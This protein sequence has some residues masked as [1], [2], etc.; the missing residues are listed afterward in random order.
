MPS[1]NQQIRELSFHNELL[2]NYFR[3]T[4]IPQLFIDGSLRL[5]KFSPPA[6][7]QFSLADSDIG[8][9]VEEIKDNF[10][11]PSIIDNIQKVIDTG[12]V[13]EKEIQT[14]DRRWYQ[15]NI[16]PYIR[17]QD[18]KTDGVIITFVEITA[19]IKDLKEQEKLVADYQILLDTISHD[20]KNPLTNLVLAV[21]LFKKATP[22][23]TKQY[24]ALLETVDTAL[25]KMHTL[26]N[27][28]TSERKNCHNISGNEELLSIENILEDVRLILSDN[29]TEAG[30][31]IRS[32]INV[33]EITFSRRK[34]RTVLYNL[35]NNALKF[36][37]EKRKLQITVTSYTEAGFTV[38][39]VKDNG[40]GIERDKQDEVFSKYCRLKHH[41]EGTGVGLHLIREIV[42]NAGGKI[43]LQSEVDQGSEFK[44][45]L[46]LK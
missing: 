32:E 35:I 39:A 7:K 22:G 12:E 31:M 6:M 28:L 33:S 44:V 30:A 3:N 23:D 8:R 24:H 21:A 15:M 5:Q 45:Y 38:I 40:I 18:K 46:K 29:I 16:L 4:I 26:I 27:E 11:F 19:R 9:P 41:I 25:S 13:L 34:L 10:R 1:K 37:S 17:L 14:V 20:V 43:M 36:R 2:E 42:T